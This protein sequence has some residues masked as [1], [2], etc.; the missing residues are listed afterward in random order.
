VNRLLILAKYSDTSLSCF[1]ATSP[2]PRLLHPSPHKRARGQALEVASPYSP[3]LSRLRTGFCAI[4]QL[5]LMSVLGG[6]CDAWP[7]GPEDWESVARA[8]LLRG[9]LETAQQQAET[10]LNSAEAAPAAHELLGHVAFQQRRHHEAALHFQAASDRGRFTMEMA[11]DW[12]AALLAMGQYPEAQKILSDAIARDPARADLRYRLAASYA[13]QQ[14]WKEAWPHL[15][16]IYRQGLRHSG[17]VLQLARA[18]FAEGLDVE[19]VELLEN[20]VSSTSAPDPLWEAGKLLFEKAL[21]SK[22]L[23]PLQ[24]LWQQKRGSYDVGMYL[25]LSYYLL[26]KHPESEET[27]LQIQTGPEPPLDYQVLLGSVRARLGKWEQARL[28][29]E[30][31]VKQAPQRADGF[32]NLGLFCLERGETRRALEL[33]ERAAHMSTKGTKLIYSIRSRKNCE[34][35]RPSQV[36]SKPDS[37]NGDLYSQLAEQLYLRQQS[38]SALEVFLLALNV[39]PG[40]ARAYAGIGKICWEKESVSEARAFLER[41]L[42]LHPN[43]ADLHFNLGLIFQSLGEPSEAV[44]CFQKAITL[45]GSEVRAL[46]WIQLGTAQ[47]SS[48]SPK[49]AESAFLIGLKRDPRLAQGHFELGKLYLQQSNLERAEQSLERAIQLDPKLLGAYYQLGLACLRSGKTEKSKDLLSTFQRKKELY[50]PEVAPGSA[51]T[52]LP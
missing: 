39:D 27:L 20:L 31:A 10:A 3:I 44:R 15:E 19:A 41:G 1:D 33:F 7:A 52:A 37:M 43:S 6:R 25:A 35:L 4:L 14:L 42:E 11:S 28:E 34:G 17:V 12:S 30:R 46:D 45:R 36:T 18:R 40:S 24:R 2:S 5:C 50:D 9:D 32:L 23:L 51:L 26:E 22:A 21:Y 48:G 38:G 8:A 47:Q 29:L 13:E 16:A 49:E